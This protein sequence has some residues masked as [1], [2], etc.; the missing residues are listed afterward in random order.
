MASRDMALRDAF[1]MQLK[2]YIRP[3][4]QEEYERFL[5][6]AGDELEKL[7]Q[8]NKDVLIRLKERG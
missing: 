3:L 4:E 7:M 8:E 5:G 2:E 6:V 1:H